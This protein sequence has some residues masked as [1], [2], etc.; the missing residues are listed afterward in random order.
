[1]ILD[2]IEPVKYK[3]DPNNQEHLNKF[4]Y[5]LKNNRWDNSCPF[6]LEW[7][8]ESVP[9]MIK[10]KIIRNMFNVELA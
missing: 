8:H 10:D 4:E 1:M 7:P 9:H 6:F 3:F 2:T 5:F